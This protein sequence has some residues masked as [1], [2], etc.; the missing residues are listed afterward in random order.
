[1]VEWTN[2]GKSLGLLI[3]ALLV[4]I[5][6]NEMVEWTKTPSQSGIQRGKWSGKHSEPLTVDIFLKLKSVHF[7]FL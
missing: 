2:K 6:K 1:M 3:T 7:D 5:A 4:K